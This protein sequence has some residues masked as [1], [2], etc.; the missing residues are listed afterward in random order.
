LPYTA[1]TGT[2]LPDKYSIDYVDGSFADVVSGDLLGS[3]IILT[4][5][6]GAAQGTYNATIQ[7]WNST[8]PAN[9]SDPVVFTV[10]LSPPPVDIT[11]LIDVCVGSNITLSHVT[12]GGTW[13]SAS[14]AIATIVTATATTGTLTGV[15]AGTSDIT[16][17][18]NGCAS[19]PY[20]VTVHPVPVMTLTVTPGLDEI[21]NGDDTE[22]DLNLTTGTAPYTFTISDGTDFYIGASGTD[23]PYTPT[24]AMIPVWG[25]VGPFTTTTYEITLI[26]DVNSCTNTGDN[27]VDV[28]VYKVPETGNTFTP[29]N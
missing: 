5:P 1:T 25:G 6:G 10:T 3:P 16:Y 7:I 2:P 21:C 28:M 13:T 18:V 8:T 29:P 20:E 17:T 14:P 23:D 12:S 4:V 27:I 9:L 24:G 15:A 22:I 11:G 26:T 19:P